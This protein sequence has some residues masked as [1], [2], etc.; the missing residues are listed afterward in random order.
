MADTETSALP[1]SGVILDTDI[2]PVS[3]A[4]VW[5]AALGSRFLRMNAGGTDAKVSVTAGFGSLT[6]ANTGN[7]GSGFVAQI[8]GGTNWFAG[9]RKDATGGTAGTERWNLLYGTTPFLTFNTNGAMLVGA[10]YSA[11]FGSA[12]TVAEASGA[13]GP[14]LI[15]Y[16]PTTATRS[17]Q[18]QRVDAEGWSGTGAALYIGKS[19]T[20]S[21]SI[22]AGGTLNASGADYAEYVVKGAGCGTIAKGD[23]C[24]I[25]R[26]GRLTRSWAAA[27]R[28]VVKSTDP[29]YVGGDGWD[30]HVPSRPIEPGAEPE[31]PALPGPRPEVDDRLDA[32]AALVEAYP[33]AVAAQADAHAAWSREVAAFD[34]AMSAWEAELEAARQTVDRIAFCG[35][36]PVNVDAAV[37]AVCEA[38]L[39][40]NEAVYLVAVAH[41]GGITA[42]AVVEADMTLPLYMRRLGAVWA[43]RD[44]RPIIDVQ[45]G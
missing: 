11:P 9:V 35:Q 5:K 19:T 12:H 16:S 29:G 28:F 3:R 17:G 21:R 8:D 27:V 23:A 6:V 10:A 31:P 41:G 7:F 30:R 44:R 26:D 43:I 37:L 40:A 33:A 14:I 45:H 2:I 24:G 25:D 39:A 22:N 4:S 20:T 18:F 34:V 13:S 38:A 32:W 36:V 1:D 15:A 42:A